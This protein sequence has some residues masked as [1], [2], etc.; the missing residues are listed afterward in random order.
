MKRLLPAP[1]EKAIPLEALRAPSRE[2]TGPGLRPA[3]Y[4][5][6]WLTW[7]GQRTPSGPPPPSFRI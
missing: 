6:S 7:A 4:P 5:L 2:A 1:A 3:Q